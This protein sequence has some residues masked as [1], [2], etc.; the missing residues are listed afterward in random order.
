M[1]MAATVS[2]DRKIAIW[3]LR[4]TN[5]PMLVNEESTASV[6]AVDFSVDQKSVITATFGGKINVIDLETQERRVDYDIMFLQ[7]DED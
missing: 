1:T 2:A 4:N 3:D 5:Q 7:P 6:T